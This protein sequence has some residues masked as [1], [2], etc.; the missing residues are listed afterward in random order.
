MSKAPLAARSPRAM[1]IAAGLVLLLT[2]L[3]SAQ[4]D[5]PVLRITT[6]PFEA[7]AIY[8]QR[9]APGTVLSLNEA[10]V[11]AELAARIERIAVR[12]GDSVQAGDELARLD[13]RDA[14]L[15]LQRAQARWRLAS[16]QLE[17]TRSLRSDANV[18][19]E[20]LD[21][22][23]A[24]FDEAE[25]ARG[26]A[27]LAEARCS[28]RAPYAGLV[29]E[30]LASEGEWATPGTPLLHLLDTGRIEVSTQVPLDAIS[31]LAAAP[32]VFFEDASGRYALEARALLPA[33]NTR[34]R[35]R[36]ARFVFRD[37]QAL[38]GSAGRVVWRAGDAHLPADLLVRRDAGLGVM[39]VVNGRARFEPLPEARE[40]QP[41]PA[42]L[43]GDAQLILDGRFGAMHGQAVQIGS[44]E[45]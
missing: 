29:M 37:A 12:V 43:P 6:A 35:H 14:R 22:R 13:C 45:P 25:V 16:Q 32:E 26:E 23:R 41:A 15:R 5:E 21:Q 44:A 3:A 8:P 1:R 4:A 36:E 24:E 10:R 11:S 30:R 38:P 42:D 18:S 19:E 39:R 33:V 7:L 28:V 40:G 34:A 20:L 17:R 31:D 27:Q 9:S 2:S